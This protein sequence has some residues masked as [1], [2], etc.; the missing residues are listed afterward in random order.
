MLCL[1]RLRCRTHL[2]QWILV[3]LE[4]G[5]VAATKPEK[6]Q[7]LRNTEVGGHACCL[8]EVFLGMQ[9]GLREKNWRIYIVLTEVSLLVYLAFAG[10]TNSVRDTAR[11]CKHNLSYECLTR[12]R[13]GSSSKYGGF[14]YMMK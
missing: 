13:G 5:S 1:R 9:D 12:S 11:S 8:K 14:R 2:L 7:I 6:Q 3:K 10:W 4:E